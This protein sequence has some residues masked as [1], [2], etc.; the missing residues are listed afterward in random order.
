MKMR[1]LTNE[2]GLIKGNLDF[3]AIKEAIEKLTNLEDILENHKVVD[4]ADLN[5]RLLG[6]KPCEEVSKGK[7]YFKPY[8]KFE[9]TETEMLEDLFQVFFHKVPTISKANNCGLIGK[10]TNLVDKKNNKLNVGDVVVVK[11]KEDENT[12]IEKTTIIVEDDVK[13]VFF[14]MGFKKTIYESLT[15]IKKCSD[16]KHGEKYANCIKVILKEEE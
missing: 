16:L 15:R 13:G 2:S 6:T 5:N 10:E 9:T 12:T 8:L 14:P 3:P 7:K 1:R 11:F 4:Y